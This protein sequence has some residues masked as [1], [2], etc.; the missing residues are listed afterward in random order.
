MTIHYTNH[1]CEISL[2]KVIIHK[3]K[4]DHQISVQINP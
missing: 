1:L 2:Y 4:E 3:N